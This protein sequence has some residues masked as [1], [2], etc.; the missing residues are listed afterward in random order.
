MVYLHCIT[1]EKLCVFEIRKHNALRHSIP[2][3][4]LRSDEKW[5]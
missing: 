3:I 4:P 5:F 2:S 1:S